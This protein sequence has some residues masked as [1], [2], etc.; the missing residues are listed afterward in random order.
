MAWVETHRPL[1]DFIPVIDNIIFIFS[2]LFG[3]SPNF[4]VFY[5]YLNLNLY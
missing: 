1:R 5:A 2:N 3:P 4:V